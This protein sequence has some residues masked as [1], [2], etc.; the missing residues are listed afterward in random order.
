MTT[1]YLI[2]GLPGSGKSTLAEQM[3]ATGMV[4]FVFEADQYF[5]DERGDY[6]F[7]PSKLGVAH[8]APRQLTKMHLSNH[9]SVAVP[10][11][12]TTEKEVEVYR[13]IAEAMGA[14]FVSIVMENRHGSE[15]VHNVPADKVQ[16][17]KNRFSI[18][19]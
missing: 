14:N 3:K 10:N 9:I 18:K 7:D 15:N 16:Q 4:G 1:L 2:R 11:T 6:C 5:V 19:L 8:L 12:S 17:M 13:K